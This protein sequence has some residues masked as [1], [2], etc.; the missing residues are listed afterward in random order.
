MTPAA[1]RFWYRPTWG[2]LRRTL[3]LSAAG[4]VWFELVYF[5]ANWL[6]QQRRYRVRLHTDAELAVAF[7]PS[8]VVGYMSL[9]P[10]FMMAP[11]VLRTERELDAIVVSQAVVIGVAG[12]GFLLFPADNVF[13]TPDEM[14]GWSSVVRF[15][16]WLALDH[17]LAP[18]LHVAM[19]ALCAAVYARRAPPLGRAALWLWAGVIGLSTLLLHQHYIIDILTGYLLA[20][21]V[22]RW[23]YDPLLRTRRPNP[24]M[25]PTLPV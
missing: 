12:I 22:L 3:L 5:G 14:G 25:N 23:V 2:R 13:P 4:C 6:T 8:A 16:K 7:V 15:A 17:N 11:F 24:A 10:L 19:G 1:Q 21:G 20:F 9:Y 18:S